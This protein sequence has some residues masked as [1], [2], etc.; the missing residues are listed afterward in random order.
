MTMPF[1]AEINTPR[2]VLH[3]ILPKI[4]GEGVETSDLQLIDGYALVMC[5]PKTCVELVLGSTEL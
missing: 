1:S 2:R 3:Q 4:L 5:D